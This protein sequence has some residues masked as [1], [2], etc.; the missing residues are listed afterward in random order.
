MA[1]WG[2]A[3]EQRRF[4]SFL[5]TEFHWITAWG[6]GG[7]FIAHRQ[8]VATLERAEDSKRGLATPKPSSK[9]LHAPV[10][11]RQVIWNPTDKWMWDW[12]TRRSISF[13]ITVVNFPLVRESLSSFQERSAGKLGSVAAASCSWGCLNM[14]G[15]S[16]RSAIRKRR[17][18]RKSFLST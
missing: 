4:Q 14:T 8:W 7:C 5:S 15:A 13:R 17:C 18:R 16:P 3:M 6:R 12:W 11:A 10:R 2:A 9:S 1:F